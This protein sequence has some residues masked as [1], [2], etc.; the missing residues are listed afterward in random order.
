M[1]PIG[2]TWR[3]SATPGSALVQRR[4][5]VARDPRVSYVQLA[6]VNTPPAA[7]A[8]YQPPR[9][10]DYR[11]LRDITAQMEHVIPGFQASSVASV[12][13]GSPPPGGDTP[14]LGGNTPPPGGD[15]P[16]GS[17]DTPGQR[18]RPRPRCVAAAQR[19]VATRRRRIAAE[20]R[21]V[22]AR[23]RASGRHTGHAAR[24]ET[25]D[26]VLHLCRYVT[27]AT[28]VRHTRWL[29]RCLRGGWCIHWC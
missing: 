9:V 1:G 11:G 3:R 7:K 15:T 10:A 27:Q 5:R 28:V 22:A 23:R 29:I 25:R 8:A 12:P 19:R 6:P 17:G 2:T 21:I 14:P 26:H 16:L 24:R 4:R 20:R 13:T 18:A